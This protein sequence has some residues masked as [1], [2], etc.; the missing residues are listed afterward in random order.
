MNG[1]VPYLHALVNVDGLHVEN[2]ML[3]VISFIRDID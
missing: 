2:R 1:S 3:V